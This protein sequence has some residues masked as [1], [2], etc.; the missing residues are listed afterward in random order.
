MLNEANDRY[1]CL[2][3]GKTVFR[4]TVE[5]FERQ[6]QAQKDKELADAGK[7]T[8]AWFGNEYWDDKKKQWREGER[9]E[10]ISLGGNRWLWI[11]VVFILASL[12]I[13]FLVNYFHP[14]SSFAFFAW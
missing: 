6:V 11:V 1:E 5:Q 4:V 2:Y 14:G 12:G 7:P 3:C 10:R 8:K 9:P 13:T